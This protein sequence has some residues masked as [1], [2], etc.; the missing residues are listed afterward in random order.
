MNGHE[1]AIKHSL[2]TFEGKLVS[3]DLMFKKLVTNI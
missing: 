1:Y 3:F 2:N